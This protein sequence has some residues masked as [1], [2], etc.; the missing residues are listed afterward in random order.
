MQKKGREREGVMSRK[1]SQT[2][3]KC[4]HVKEG[5]KRILR[6]HIC[7]TVFRLSHPPKTAN[8]HFIC[9]YRVIVGAPEDDSEQAKVGIGKAGAV[10]RCQ[11]QM[12]FRCLQIP[13]DTSGKSTQQIY[14][15]S[16]PLV[17]LHQS[18]RARA[19]G[20]NSPFKILPLLTL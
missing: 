6:G 9:F 12:P 8:K 20:R 18:F 13:F 4:T 17:R 2:S 15:F 11:T 3:P 14:D 7:N 1:K 10:Y 5:V 16:F 19:R